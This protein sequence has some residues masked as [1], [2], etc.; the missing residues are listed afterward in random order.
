MRNLHEVLSYT[1]LRFDLHIS[2]LHRWLEGKN[3]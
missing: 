1:A 2:W 3:G